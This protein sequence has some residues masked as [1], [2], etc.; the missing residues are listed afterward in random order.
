MLF[1]NSFKC[2]YKECLYYGFISSAVALILM[3]I[4]HIYLYFKLTKMALV[5]YGQEPL[6]TEEYLIQRELSLAD[7]NPK[8]PFSDTVAWR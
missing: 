7:M 4:I 8:Q 5:K 3:I 1:E 2:T 6:P